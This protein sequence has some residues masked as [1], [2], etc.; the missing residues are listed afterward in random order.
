MYINKR[1]FSMLKENATLVIEISTYELLS[2][3]LCCLVL[4]GCSFF[5]SAGI[6]RNPI[7]C[8][9]IGAVIVLLLLIQSY[10]EKRIVMGVADN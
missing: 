3:I 6:D 10:I 2:S 8:C 1:L 7:R 4:V 9:I 5:L